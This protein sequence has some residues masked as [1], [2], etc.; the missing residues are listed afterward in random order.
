M[1]N[2]QEVVGLGMVPLEE[3][4][5]GGWSSPLEMVTFESQGKKFGTMGKKL[6]LGE[7]GWGWV[8]ARELEEATNGLQGVGGV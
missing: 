4:S 6:S 3:M 5:Q 7:S 1:D 2:G 8:L